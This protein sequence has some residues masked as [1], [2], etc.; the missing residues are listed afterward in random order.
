[1]RLAAWEISGKI[2]HC[3][4]FQSHLPI[5]SVELGES[6]LRQVMNRSGESGVAGVMGRKLIYSCVI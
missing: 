4:E 2:W 1:M 5:L 6:Q 3:Q